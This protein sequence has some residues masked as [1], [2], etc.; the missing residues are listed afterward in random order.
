MCRN[1]ACWLFSFSLPF[2]PTP[3]KSVIHSWTLETDFLGINHLGSFT[4]WLWV[5]FRQWEA[6]AGDQREEETTIL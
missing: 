1:K 4:G 3:F 5:G 6:P 2:S